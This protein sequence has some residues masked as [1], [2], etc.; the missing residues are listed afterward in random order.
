MV[1]TA[2]ACVCKSMD[3]EL[4]SGGFQGIDKCNHPPK[5]LTVSAVPAAPGYSSHTFFVDSFPN[6]GE[7]KKGGK[8]C[9]INGV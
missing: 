7:E 3:G 5:P 2:L 1:K 9:H 8:L 6:F 4:V